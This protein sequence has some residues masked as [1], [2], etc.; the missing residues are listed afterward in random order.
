MSTTLVS[1]P[2]TAFVRETL[3]PAEVELFEDIND[4]KKWPGGVDIQF[5][6]PRNGTIGSWP[7]TVKYRE[8]VGI[9]LVRI[10]IARD[11]EGYERVK[12]LEDNQD[13][14]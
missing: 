3:T 9:L 1:E 13:P 2:L 7:E 4:P 5:K 6:A 10:A 14:K 8:I 11:P 12:E